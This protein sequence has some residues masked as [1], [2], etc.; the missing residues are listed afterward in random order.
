MS[1]LPVVY[2]TLLLFLALSIIYPIT[3]PNIVGIIQPKPRL[4]PGKYLLGN[5]KI[6][7]TKLLFDIDSGRFINKSKKAAKA[8]RASVHLYIVSL[9]PVLI[10]TIDKKIS[11]IDKGYKNISTGM[12]KEIILVNPRFAIKNETITNI[13]QYCL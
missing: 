4:N 2:V 10:E 7:V 11:A 8:V 13:I 5:V 9:L 12:D 6:L 1:Y 3:N